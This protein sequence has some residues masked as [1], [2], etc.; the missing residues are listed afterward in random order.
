MINFLKKLLVLTLFIGIT[1]AGGSY[2]YFQIYINKPHGPKQ[3][4][5]FSVQKG[6]T[7]RPVLERLAALGALEHPTWLYLYA[8]VKK[9]GA[10]QHG[11]YSYEG[12]KSP[13]ELLQVLKDGAIKLSQFTIPEGFNRWQIKEMLVQKGWLKANDFEKL[14]DDSE[15]LAAEGIPGPNCEGY[16]FPETYTFAQGVVPK[17]LFQTMFAQYKKTFASISSG[18]DAPL[19]LNQRELTTLASIVEKETGS[20]GE[21]SRIACVF[22]NRMQAKPAWRLETDPTVIYAATLAEPGFD[23]NIKRRHL[24]E[25]KHP[26]NTYL[27]KGLPPG[28]I[29]S[30]GKKALQAV[31][32]PETCPYFFFVSKNN[33]AHQFCETLDCHNANVQRWQINY[34]KSK[35]AKTEKKNTPPN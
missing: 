24:R 22:Y 18:K 29:A 4:T 30:P 21:R 17:T 6:D 5:K 14:C 16:L 20:S 27:T 7:L 13:L 1:L 15:F 25:L 19:G 28:P 11:D 2:T 34:F 32:E 31:F 12:P 26:Y 8:R 10:I 35:K 3:T 23:G 9:M 33:G